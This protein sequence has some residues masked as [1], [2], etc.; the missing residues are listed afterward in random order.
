MT[1]TVANTAW[2]LNSKLNYA[3]VKFFFKDA[4]SMNCVSDE[5]VAALP[6]EDFTIPE[7]LTVFEDD[8]IGLV[9]A[10]TVAISKKKTGTDRRTVCAQT[11]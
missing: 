1:P 6:D 3:D 4:D 2:T 8:D 5:A 9:P 7:S 11:V 10:Q